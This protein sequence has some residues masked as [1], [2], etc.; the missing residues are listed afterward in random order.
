[1]AW[2]RPAVHKCRCGLDFRDVTPKSAD[3]DLLAINTA[4]YR[5]AGATVGEAAELCADLRFPPELFQLKLGALLRLIL[6]AGSIKEGNILRRKQR[7]FGATNLLAATE[8]C[9]GAVMMLRDWPRPLREVL[10]RMISPVSDNPAALNFSEIFGNFYRHLFRVLPRQEFG[11]LHNVFE[12][13]VIDDWKGFIRGQHRY[14]SAAVR[15]DSHWVTANEAEKLAHMAGGRILDLVRHRQLESILLSARRGGTRTEYWIRR[16][17]L[18][19]WIA[20][21]DLELTRYMPRP[22]AQRTLGLTNITVLAPDFPP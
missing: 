10:R 6:F 15:R 18:D 17:S 11:F 12:R 16:E 4:I 2:Q 5:A 19:R 14:F 1:V 20:N 8:I 21:R 22:E 13:F 7:P 3:P 9:C